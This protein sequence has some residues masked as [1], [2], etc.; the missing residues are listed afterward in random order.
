MLTEMA[1]LNDQMRRDQL[2][3]DRLKTETAAIKSQTRAL[4][5]AMGASE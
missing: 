4:L 2:A 1:H 3:I 5:A